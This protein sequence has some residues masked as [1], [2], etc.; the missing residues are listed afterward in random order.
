V[1]LRATARLAVA[2]LAAASG[3]GCPRVPREVASD[4]S[5]LVPDGDSSIQ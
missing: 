4:Q 1:P 2:A 5:S 3:L